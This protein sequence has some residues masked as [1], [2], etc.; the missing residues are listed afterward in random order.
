[1][2]SEPYTT[3]PLWAYI[4]D[5]L[6]ARRATHGDLVRALGVHRSRLTDWKRG[7][8]MTPSTARTLAAFLDKPLLEVLVANGFLTPEEAGAPLALRQLSDYDDLALINELRRR[9]RARGHTEPQTGDGT[10]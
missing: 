10:A 3:P 9:L 2:S 5:N 7:K 8:A 1:M 6:A 4:E